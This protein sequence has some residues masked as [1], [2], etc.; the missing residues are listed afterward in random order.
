MSGAADSSSRMC[1]ENAARWLMESVPGVREVAP[2]QSDSL[3]V[4]RFAS[5]LPARALDP[6]CGSGGMLRYSGDVLVFDAAIH[7]SNLVADP[8]NPRLIAAR[9]YAEAMRELR[10]AEAHRDLLVEEYHH[11][12]AS[13]VV[14]DEGDCVQSYDLV[15]GQFRSLIVFDLSP[16]DVEAWAEA[17]TAQALGWSRRTRR[18]LFRVLRAAL[19]ACTGFAPPG[20]A[21]LSRI[22][23]LFRTNLVGTLT[24]NAPPA[25]A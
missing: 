8:V 25:V 7:G 20:V 11:A 2:Q 18:H 13:L 6:T 17:Q 5:G 10:R 14:V 24:R 21:P 3:T 19:G 4:G 15:D 23:T 12:R 9:S 1:A 16:D 22:T